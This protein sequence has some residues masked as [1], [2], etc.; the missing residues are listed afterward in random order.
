MI[1]WNYDRPK[2]YSSDQVESRNKYIQSCIDGT[3]KEECCGL[4]RWYIP[5]NSMGIDGIC[6]KS[7]P[8]GQR[9]RVSIYEHCGDFKKQ[10]GKW[11]TVESPPSSV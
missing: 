6:V 1:D 2:I 11:K 10:P 9:A 5:E 4:C 7:A 3:S 8:V